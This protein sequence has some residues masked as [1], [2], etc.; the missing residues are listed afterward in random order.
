MSNQPKEIAEGAAKDIANDIDQVAVVVDWLDACRRHELG[1]L[2]DLYAPEASLECDC[3]DGNTC[4]GRAAL[5]SYWRPRLEA[6][7]PNAFGLEEITPSADG[8]M[9]DYLNSEGKPVRIVFTFDAAGKILQTRCAP[10][11]P[12][13]ALDVAGA[14]DRTW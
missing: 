4:A 10:F 3:D 7:S 9:L 13:T 1:P 8:V 11:A 6:F 12:A 5:E 14:P 2:L